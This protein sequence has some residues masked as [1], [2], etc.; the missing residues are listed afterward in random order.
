V[1]LE[2]V[3]ESLVARLFVIFPTMLASDASCHAVLRGS[4]A[5]PFA[6]SE[7]W[8]RRRNRQFTS[9]NVYALGRE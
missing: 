5:N 8:S 1:L 9:G 4:F 7:R 6:I 2:E 3:P